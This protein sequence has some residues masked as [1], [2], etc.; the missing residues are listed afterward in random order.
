MRLLVLVV[1]L[2]GLS[3]TPTVLAEVW[4]A[5]P[6]V[7]VA[8]RESDSTFLT[9]T[10]S[11]GASQYAVFAGSHRGSLSLVGM[12]AGTMFEDGPRDGAHYYGVAA[13]NPQGQ[14]SD[15][16]VVGVARSE[17]LATTT[18][19]QVTLSIQGCMNLIP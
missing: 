16:Q 5:P 6:A 17:C 14:F 19:F 18:S 15:I 8:Y 4:G 3:A 13:V 9:W 10:P 7:V 11:P 12:T 1:A 2:V